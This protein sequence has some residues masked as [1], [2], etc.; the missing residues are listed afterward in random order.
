M[1]RL[2]EEKRELLSQNLAQDLQLEQ[3]NQSHILLNLL[4]ELR[5]QLI[6]D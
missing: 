2:S 3:P 1:T 5:P 4:S 6:T